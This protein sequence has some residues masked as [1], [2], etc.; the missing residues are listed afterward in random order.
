M[1][2]CA[3]A[4]VIRFASLTF[5]GLTHSMNC[6]CPPRHRRNRTRMFGLYLKRHRTRSIRCLIMWLRCHQPVSAFDCR[7]HPGTLVHSILL[8]SSFSNLSYNSSYISG[9]VCLFPS[10]REQRMLLIS[11]C[12]AA[13]VP[14][15]DT[16]HALKAIIKRF[17][18]VIAYK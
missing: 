8:F 15:R 11:L 13:C 3:N 16:F 12:E 17:R 9:R 6:C 14:R 5:I 10:A 18:Y 1:L 7:Y 4:T 2:M